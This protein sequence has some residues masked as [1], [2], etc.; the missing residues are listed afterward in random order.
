LSSNFTGCDVSGRDKIIPVDL[1]F[2]ISRPCP[3]LLTITF[4]RIGSTIEYSDHVFVK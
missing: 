2:L 1:I 4:L 3:N